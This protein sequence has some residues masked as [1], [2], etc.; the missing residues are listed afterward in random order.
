MDTILKGILPNNSERMFLV[1][2]KLGP[3][4]F[5]GE[6]RDLWKFVERISD[7]TGGKV[8][9]RAVLDK[10]LVGAE[11][12]PIE[13]KAKVEELWNYIDSLEDVDEVDFRASVQFLIDEYQKNKLGES[14]TE[15]MEIL[16]RGVQRGHVY[17]NGVNDSLDNIRIVMSDIERLS[18]ASMPEGDIRKE[19]LDILREFQNMNVIE[20]IPTGIVPLDNLT[21][22]GIGLGE[23]WLLAAFAGTG[24]TMGCTNIAHHSCITGKNVLILTAETLREQVRQRILIR[25]SR[26][27][28]FGAVGGLSSESI[29]KHTPDNK[30]MS[31]EAV[32]VWHSVID[33]F[34]ENSSYGAL[35]ISQIPMGMKVSSLH[36][37][38]N[39][40]FVRI[41]YDLVIIDSLDLLT[42]EVRRN[43][44]RE[45]LN[46]ILAA[47]KHLATSF[48]NGNGLR[49]LSPWQTSRDA[50]RK[51]KE[52]G[53]YDKSSMAETAEAERKADVIFSLL[54]K[55]DSEY[56]LK[57]QV[58][59][60]RDGKEGEFDLAFDADK[61]F[62]GSDE[63]YEKSWENSLMELL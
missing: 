59:K 26:L 38:L 6:Y 56:R 7:I 20:K 21:V 33:D 15:S 49:I 13:R 51:A 25:H 46:G 27:P 2:E 31:Q 55:G 54:D 18:L 63:D 22:G 30:A 42:P 32:N 41:Q 1:Q 39:K 19:K 5:Y 16:T 4:Y 17:L 8:I 35:N 43:T 14:L 24:K 52:T 53:G 11:N 12:L 23:L 61:C 37:K 45:E 44:D 40:M 3:E 9:S 50:W 47:A 29:K 62:M 58:L 60:N 10:M 57:A 36:A 34:T 48:D 28:Q